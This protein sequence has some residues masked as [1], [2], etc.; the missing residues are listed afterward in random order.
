MAWLALVFACWPAA[1]ALAQAAPA[2]IVTTPAGVTDELVLRDGTHA[3]GRVERV[4]DGLVTFKTTAG[5]E[6]QVRPADI[7]SVRP[8]NGTVVA[9]EFRRADPNPTRLFFGPT[10]R[11]LKPGTG[12]VGVYEI[13]LPFV[14]V[15]CVP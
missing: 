2:R 9:G 7:V 4:E 14:Q 15:C 1:S 13:V 3:Y 5:A 12:Y 6:I 8:V 11:S 10:A